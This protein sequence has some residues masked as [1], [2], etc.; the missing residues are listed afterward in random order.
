VEDQVATEV[1][2]AAGEEEAET[3]DDKEQTSQGQ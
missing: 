3:P 2:D 1:Q